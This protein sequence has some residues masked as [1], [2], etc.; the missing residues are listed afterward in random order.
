VKR[1]ALTL[2]VA[3]CL[4]LFLAPLQTVSARDSWTSVRSKNFYL[5][6]NASEKDIRRIGVQLEQFRD[7]LTRLI[8]N[9]KSVSTVPITVVVFKSDDSFKPF[10]PPTAAAYF[11]SGEDVNYIALTSERR[12]ENPYA[13]IFHEYVHFLIKNNTE[14]V[15]LW[16]NEGLAEYYSSFD[17]MD[18]DKKVMIG[19]P[20]NNHVLYLRQ[21]KMM[22]LETLFAVTHDSPIYNERDKQG[23]FYA[24]SWALVHYLLLGSEGK[25][26]PQ[27]KQFLNLLASDMAVEAAFK[28]A[29]QTD[30]R[31]LEKELKQYIGRN[32][33]TVSVTTFNEKLAFDT[34]MQSAPLTDAEGQFYLGD[35]LL[36]TSQLDR[37]EKYLQEAVK[38][39]PNLAIAHASLGMLE[40]RREHFDE[41]KKHLQRAVASDTKNYLV[42]YYYAYMLSRDGMHGDSYVTGFAPEVAATMREEL[43]KAIALAPDYAESYH[44]LAFINLVTGEQLDES[45][46]L[47][48]RAMTLAPGEQRFGNVLA[49][50]YIRKRDYKTARQILEPIARNTAGDDPQSRAQ[51]QSL[52]QT[53]STIE[54]HEARYPSRD[55]GGENTGASPGGATAPRLRRRADGEA[56]PTPGDTDPRAAFQQA[57]LPKR[58]GEE[59]VRGQLLRIDCNAQGVTMTIKVGDRTLKLH[60]NDLVNINFI[61]FTEEM[62]GDI[63]CGPRNPANPVIINYRAAK[64]AKSKTDGE[65]TAIAFLSKELDAIQ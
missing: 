12:D 48:K 37:A 25:R 54:E 5:V 30:F 42:H 29:F 21:Q 52:L 3:V 7:V 13:A 33:Y 64:D 65:V 11:Q 17:M 56:E 61:T 23:V 35:L 27:F 55:S 22:P 32:S 24:E 4:T 16:F 19:K 39:D 60:N 57:L 47:L 18:G 58:E 51:A 40:V 31:T 10:R 6:G 41:A 45:I 14:N 15:P 43:R 9:V 49:Q 46:E 26:T 53:I 50:L 62:R 34:E 1:F 44:L 59:Q 28:Q 8:A 38:L 36:H 2:A 63:G 20:I